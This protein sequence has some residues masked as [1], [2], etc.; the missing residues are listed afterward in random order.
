[1]RERS[2]ANNLPTRH[3][4]TVSETSRCAAMTSPHD[5]ISLAA[6]DCGDVRRVDHARLSSGGAVCVC[7]CVSEW[8]ALHVMCRGRNI[9]RHSSSSS[10]TSR[11]S[12]PLRGS[13]YFTVITV[14]S[15]RFHFFTEIS[16]KIVCIF[17]FGGGSA[18]ALSLTSDH[19]LSYHNAYR[20]RQCTVW[21][22]KTWQQTHGHNS[23]KS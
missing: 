22:I 1:M 7:V 19:Y 12:T 20:S 17:F 11:V 8:V 9:P 18:L 10:S 21:S 16:P 2:V 6:A 3:T 5:V 14:R 23:V 15:Q 4:Q 13:A